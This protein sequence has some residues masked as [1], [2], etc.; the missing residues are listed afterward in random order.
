MLFVRALSILLALAGAVRA[1]DLRFHAEIDPQPFILG[2]Y[3]GQVGVRYDHLR[4]AVASFALDEPDAIAQL[5]G[6]D[7]FHVELRPSGAF[8]VLYY[9]GDR[10]SWA[11]GGSMRLLRFEYTY[12]GDPAL[13]H[14]WELSPE[15]IAAYKWQ[16]TSTGFYLQPWATISTTLYRHGDTQVGTHHYDPLPIGLFATVNIGWELR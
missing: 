5:G 8:Y 7:H 1:D 3:G 11:F 4:A 13:A 9:L 12:D 6:N 10:S 2:G 15:A 16:P 14:T